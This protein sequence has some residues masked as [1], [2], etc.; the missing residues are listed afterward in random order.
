M[1]GALHNGKSNTKG[2]RISVTKWKVCHTIKA[3]T[4][5]STGITGLCGLLHDSCNFILHGSSY[6]FQN[7]LICLVS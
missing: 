7:D 4:C 5:L 6:P 2:P 1:R 3:P